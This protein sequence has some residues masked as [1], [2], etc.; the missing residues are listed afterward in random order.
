M[1]LG[2]QTTLYDVAFEGNRSTTESNLLAVVGLQ[3]GRPASNLG[4]EQARRQI[5]QTY[6]ESGHAYAEVSSVFDMSP[7]HWHARAL[8]IINESQQV[9]VDRISV[10]GARRT[11][12]SLIRRRVALRVREPYRSGDIR[13]IEER[14]ATLGV[15]HPDFR[16]QQNSM[17]RFATYML[18]ELPLGSR[19][20]S[21]R[22]AIGRCSDPQ[23]HR[24]PSEVP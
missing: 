16:T 11:R 23:T 12:E 6:R 8:F 14:I 5:V 22:A 20:R 10:V 24:S 2:P 15:A 7:D 9:I 21:F 18:R 4:L 19:N 1:K 13:K 17:P 3:L